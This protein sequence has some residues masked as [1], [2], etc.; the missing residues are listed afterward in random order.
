MKAG[1]TVGAGDVVVVATAGSARRPA[2]VTAPGD[3]GPSGPP[4]GRTRSACRAGAGPQIAPF[5]NAS[6]VMLGRNRTTWNRKPK[7]VRGCR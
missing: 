6:R 7:T 5:P 3:A 1:D 2:A 4:S